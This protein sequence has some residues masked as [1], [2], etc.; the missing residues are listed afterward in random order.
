[1]GTALS[2]TQLDATAVVP[3]TTTAVPGTYT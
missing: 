2:A 1:V 3:G